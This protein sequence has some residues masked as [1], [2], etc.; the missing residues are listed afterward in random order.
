ML[1]S[2]GAPISKYYSS[3]YTIIVQE[4][5]EAGNLL[6]YILNPDNA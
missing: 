5:Y 6:S 1:S 3:G 2:D 4:H